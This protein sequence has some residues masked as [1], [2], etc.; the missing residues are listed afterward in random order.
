MMASANDLEETLVRLRKNIEDLATSLSKVKLSSRVRKKVET[1]VESLSGWLSEIQEELDPVH[2]PSAVFDPSSPRTIGRFISIAMIAQ[3][4]V[5]LAGV[6]T[7]YGSGI[8]AIYYKGGYGLYEPLSKTET[9]IYVGKADPATSVAE[10]PREQECRLA[11]RLG[12]HSKNISRAESTLDINDFECRWLVVSSG[13][14]AAAEA[15]MIDLFKPVWTKETKVIVGFGKHGD[16]AETRSNRRSPW[17]TLHPARV[18]A[19]NESLEDKKSEDQIREE[20]KR[21]FELHP[22]FKDRAAI[23]EGFFN[24]LRQS[25][26]I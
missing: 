3:E 16:S 26:T 11:R 19:M 22:T 18:W 1:E 14:E 7:F 8:Y 17:D 20:V 21:H 13:W 2:Q 12:D 4:R 6:K 9:P 23:L 25:K 15:Y 24:E 10:D 5:P